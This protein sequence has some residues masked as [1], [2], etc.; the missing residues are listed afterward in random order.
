MKIKFFDFSN[1]KCENIY[2]MDERINNIYICLYYI[3][4]II[5]E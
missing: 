3:F 2:L 4:N 5:I 1:L